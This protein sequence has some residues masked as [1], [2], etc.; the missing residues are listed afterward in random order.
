LPTHPGRENSL[1][2]SDFRLDHIRNLMIGFLPGSDVALECGILPRNCR[3]SPTLRPQLVCGS[4]RQQ[5]RQL[6]RNRCGSTCF[7]DGTA[8][9]GH[10]LTCLAELGSDSVFA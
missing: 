7:A 8:H 1:V 10:R 3:I 6:R 9:V 5:A 4:W 2:D